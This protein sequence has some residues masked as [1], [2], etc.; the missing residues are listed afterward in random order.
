MFET[1]IEVAELFKALLAFQGECQGVKKTS[2]NPHFKSKY[3]DLEE[4]V[5]TITPVAQ[6]HGLGYTQLPCNDGSLV[7]VT[8]MV[9]HVSG[10]WLRSSYCVPMQKNDAQ[11][12]VAA[13]TYCRRCSLTAAFGLAPEDDDGNTASQ[14]PE[15]RKE[16]EQ[17]QSPTAATTTTAKV[18]GQAAGTS[19]P[20]SQP[21]SRA[22]GTQTID[23]NPVEEAQREAITGL[24]KQ[25]N[26][27]GPGVATEIKKHT[28]KAPGDIRFADANK[29]IAELEKQVRLNKARAAQAAGEAKP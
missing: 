25:L 3:A 27:S 6:K 9:F 5:A 16:G 26:I 12:A 23:Q 29:L 8:T 15:P 7:G 1:S 21:T 13:V 24:F 18:A 22:D 11:T 14:K 17:R 10:Q 19:T 2:T 20:A 4:V 28:G